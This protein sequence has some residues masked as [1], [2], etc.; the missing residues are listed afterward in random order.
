MLVYKALLMCNYM[1]NQEELV[2]YTVLCVITCMFMPNFLFCTLQSE[3]A[4]KI[5]FILVINLQVI[6]VMILLCCV[7]L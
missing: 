4:K 6:T 2:C 3:A 7:G 1:Q 5:P